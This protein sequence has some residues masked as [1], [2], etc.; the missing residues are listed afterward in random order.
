MLYLQEVQ[1]ETIEEGEDDTP[2]LVHENK[3]IRLPV[4]QLSELGFNFSL[5]QQSTSL[6][7]RVSQIS[8][9]KLLIFYFIFIFLVKETS[10]ILFFGPL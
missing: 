10:G 7:N 2:V 1:Y 3:R 6:S 8:Y 9:T 4:P 5:K